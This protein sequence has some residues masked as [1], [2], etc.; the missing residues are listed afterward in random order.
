[1][2]PPATGLLELSVSSHSPHCSSLL[3]TPGHI[4]PT[5]PT[6]DT[7]L[8]HVAIII[9]LSATVPR[10]ISGNSI[11]FI[12]RLLTLQTAHGYS[13]CILWLRDVYNCKCTHVF[14]LEWVYIDNFFLMKKYFWDIAGFGAV[15]W[16]FTV[17]T[18]VQCW[19]FNTWLR[20][21]RNATQCLSSM[22]TLGF[23]CSKICSEQTPFFPLPPSNI[24]PP[25]PTLKKNGLAG[26]I[27]RC[28]QKS[29]GKA[30]S[31]DRSPVVTYKHL[32]QKSSLTTTWSTG[33]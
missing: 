3:L 12:S 14:L 10:N 4:D 7:G 17:H 8:V 26:S 18:C 11:S 6:S 30:Y 9:I 1:M 24:L 5:S 13:E 16:Q 29:K 32:R 25:T 2:S 22:Q 31:C 33:H 28:F 21:W 20:L 15:S 27:Q 23:Q 19:K